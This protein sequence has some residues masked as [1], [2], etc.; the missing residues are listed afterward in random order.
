MASLNYLIYKSQK[1]PKENSPMI[2][3]LLQATLHL[4]AY[5]K[6]EIR[7]APWEDV[8]IYWT[9]EQDRDSALVEFQVDEGEIQKSGDHFDA[10]VTAI[11]NKDFRV[12][13]VPE[14]KVCRECDFRTYCDSQGTI[15]F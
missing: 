3:R 10:I 4:C 9:S 11:Q 14:M 2:R 1:K 15:R 13:K 5:L 6:G 8:D 12:M 7:S